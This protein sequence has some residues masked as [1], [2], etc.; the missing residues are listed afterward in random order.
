MRNTNRHRRRPQVEAL[1]SWMPLSGAAGAI[2]AAVALRNVTP[3]VARQGQA[4]VLQG[5]VRG[6]Y[7]VSFGVPDIGSTYRIGTVGR[8]APLGQSSEAAQVHTTGF[9]AQGMA[10]GTMTIRAARGSLSLNLIGPVQPGFSPLPSTLSY[11]ITGGTRAYQN[12]S[13]T[14]TIDVTLNQG[15]GSSNFGLIT[16]NFH[17]KPTPVA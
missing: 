10:T 11:T 16:L 17:G 4:I 3:I 1:E 12:A 14:G 5:T 15:I 7:F 2:H 13:G 6:G 8:L 9:I